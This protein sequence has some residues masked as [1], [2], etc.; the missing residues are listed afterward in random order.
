M[1]TTTAKTID[2]YTS[3]Q[4]VEPFAVEPYDREWGVGISGNTDS[5]SPFPRINRILGRTSKSTNGAV[6]VDRAMLVTEAYR[7]HH[8]QPQIIKCAY[9]MAN[10]LHNCPIQIYD[11][12]LIV[13]TLGCD[14]KAGP[15]FPEFGVDWIVGEMKNGL[16]DY[17]EKRTH[18]YFSFTNE[19][20]E[21]LARLAL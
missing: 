20:L 7:K 17:S 14:N 16:M 3:A 13:G 5:P 21:K 12:E 9:A 1:G 11:D 8:A 19:D 2:A 4:R 15:V 6:S 18:D 10:H